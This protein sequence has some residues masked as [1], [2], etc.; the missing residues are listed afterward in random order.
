MV[1]R[2]P[3]DPRVTPAR[4]FFWNYHHATPIIGGLLKGL[5]PY[6]PVWLWRH[7]RS[8]EL[9]Y[10][11]SEP[12]LLVTLYYALWAKLLG[13]RLV[14]FTWE[15]L[16]YEQKFHGISSV[17]HG[18]LLRINLWLADG[19][20]CGNSLSADI[21]RRYTR[22]PIVVIP[23]NGI[24]PQRF[25]RAE[26]RP[27]AISTH[28]VFTF[29]GAIGYRKGIHHIIR[30]LPAVLRSIPNAHVI[31]AGS[32]EYEQ[33][34]DRIIDEVG[35]RD[36]VTRIPWVDHKDLVRL[37]STSDVF[38]YPSM[39]HRGWAEQFGYAMAE[40]SLMELPVIAT[41]SG[42]IPD[43]VVD[44]KTGILIPPDNTQALADAMVRLGTDE[45]LCARLGAAGRAYIM[46]RYTQSAV[47]RAMDVFFTTLL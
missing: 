27:S 35:V 41:R 2:A 37:L 23:M 26:T 10:A 21:H 22:R 42:S 36:H 29:V 1:Y 24:N 33:D 8:C 28:T 38:L 40:A 18:A 43:V 19:L 3:N 45:A 30:A 47:A 7:R 15:N 25:Q 17:I 4:A 39:P 9:V 12:I 34:I 5:M 6:F 32:G 14:L 16:P 13:K 20:V 44:E 46:E 11:C 31:I